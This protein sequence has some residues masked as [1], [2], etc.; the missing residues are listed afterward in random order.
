MGAATGI[1]GDAS[2]A[3]SERILLIEQALPGRKV[4]NI[5]GR[6]SDIDTATVPE[7]V[8][9]VGGVYTGFPTGAA[10]T[11][12]VFSSDPVD[13]SA[14]TGARTV[15]LSGLDANYLYQEETVT[16]NGVTP[17]PTTKTWTRINLAY[18]VTAGS[19]NANA[20]TITMRHT[21]TTTNVFGTI[22]IGTNE[23]HM[24]VY[25]IPADSFGSLLSWIVKLLGASANT[26]EGD[27]YVREFGKLFRHRAT[28][29]VS[30]SDVAEESY[31]GGLYLPPKTDIKI[32]IDV[33]STNNLAVVSRM[34]IY[35]CKTAYK[36]AL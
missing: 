17:V 26:I 27:L 22:P 6:N 11:V 20:G 1:I 31:E 12:E 36:G 18:V 35:E 33:A 24:C 34:Q 9:E 23:T 29:G 28:F 15:L 3:F 32:D 19:G 25:T 4:V 16:L 30:G 7:T 21:T 10:E 5:F 8:W 13:T 2:R 14:G